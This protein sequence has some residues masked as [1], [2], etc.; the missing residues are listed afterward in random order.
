MAKGLIYMQSEYQE[1][2]NGAKVVFKE[3]LIRSLSKLV[4]DIKKEK[5]LRIK[6]KREKLKKNN[7]RNRKIIK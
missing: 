1:K 4:K 7:R 5:Q 3:I 2:Q 6:R